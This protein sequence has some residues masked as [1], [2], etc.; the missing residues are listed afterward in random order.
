MSRRYI[1]TSMLS[2]L[3]GMVVGTAGSLVVAVLVGGTVLSAALP[4]KTTSHLADWKQYYPARVKHWFWIPEEAQVV[5]ADE[6][7]G[8]LLY[9]DLDIKIRLPEDRSPE[10]WLQR[11]VSKAPG[12]DP[13]ERRKLAYVNK[14]YSIQYE[15]QERLYVLHYHL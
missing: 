7:T 6:I 2:V 14:L 5:K 12:G 8:G 3:G 1:A 10:E 13:F 4:T 11:L 9:G 15:P